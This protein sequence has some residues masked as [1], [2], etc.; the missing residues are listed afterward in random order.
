MKLEKKLGEEV[1]PQLYKTPVINRSPGQTE[2]MYAQTFTIVNNQIV[3]YSLLCTVMLLFIFI[4][5]KLHLHYSH[6]VYDNLFNI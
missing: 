5:F 2:T 4:T 3:I 1:F 6:Y